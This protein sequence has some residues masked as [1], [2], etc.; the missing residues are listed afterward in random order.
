MAGVVLLVG[1]LAG[2]TSHNPARPP[3]CAPGNVE[4][5]P[6]TDVALDSGI[7]HV[8]LPSLAESHRPPGPHATN[9]TMT[10]EAPTAQETGGQG[11][12]GTGEPDDGLGADH[13]MGTATSIPGLASLA[14]GL[15]VGDID[16]D[17][18]WDLFF[19][20]EGRDHLYR[21]DCTGRF[22]DVSSRLP[23]AGDGL[24]TASLFVDY[25]G[26]GRQD[27]FVTQI[28]MPS[29]LLRNVGDHFADVSAAA[30][31]SRATSAYGVAAA[32]V[33]GDGDLDILVAN[34]YSWWTRELWHDPGDNEDP[35][36]LWLNHGDGTFT[37][38]TQESGLQGDGPTLAAA[39]G[40]YDDDGDPDLAL[41]NDFGHAASLW[42]N[43]GRGH[44]TRQTQAGFTSERDGMGTVWADL[45]GNG[46]LDM[47]IAN[48]RSHGIPGPRAL[49]DILLA[50]Q[51][52]GTFRDASQASGTEDALWAWGGVAF[53]AESDGDQ[54]LYVPDG[55]LD[56][57]PSIPHPEPG[58]PF[59]PPDPIDF[60]PHAGT[61]QPNRFFESLG[62][63]RFTER[64]QA[65]GLGRKD[66]S[67]AAAAA[68]LDGDGDVDLVTTAVAR[69]PMVLRNDAPQGHFLHLRLHSASRLNPDAIGAAAWV[70]VADRTM[71]LEQAAGMGFESQGAPE[72]HA[73]LGA[74]AQAHVRLRWPDGSVAEADLAP[75]A[76]LWSQGGQPV[77]DRAHGAA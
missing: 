6:F 59:V 13:G 51:G 17:G 63:G 48:I 23:A 75:G 20:D 70:T 67:R 3:Q 22:E 10:S 62:H 65:W 36:L 37:D 69:R 68:D 18:C 76:W 7:A 42:Q 11:P 53:D 19:A 8:T 71:R 38:G 27:L 61:L 34:Y 43:D 72:L 33:D 28:R 54:D 32:D 41:A 30:G 31:I 58:K 66:E 12:E 39:F 2:C 47:Y 50:N 24:G 56:A 5:T 73:G 55:Y 44:F 45:M 64:A 26:D 77:A 25:D 35:E 46:R 1:L 16:G 57:P 15:A 60:D 52:N 14:A 21:N 29:R 74:A 4:C 49:G 40:D 9:G